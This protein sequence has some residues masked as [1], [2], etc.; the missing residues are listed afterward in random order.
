MNGNTHSQKGDGVP[1]PVFSVLIPKNS[2]AF[3]SS[4]LAA[5]KGPGVAEI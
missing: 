5:S 4:N 1:F 3:I 2:Y